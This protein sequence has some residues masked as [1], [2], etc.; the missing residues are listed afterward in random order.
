MVIAIFVIFMIA[1]YYLG[2]KG[3]QKV[4]TAEDLIVANWDL[5]LPLVTWSLIA[6]L[7]AAPFYFAAVGSGYTTG[8]WEAFAT[9]GGLAS[10]MILGSFIW[11]KPI[12]RLKAWTIG[13]YYGLR[14]ADRKLGA[15]A[16]GIMAAAFGFFN[17][18]ALTVGG[19][20]IIQNIFNVPFWAG[21][22]IFVILT[23]IYTL[24]GG[25]WSLA[26]AD[27]LNGIVSVV[28]IVAITLVILVTKQGE[29]FNS[30][31]W[32]INHLFNKGGADFWMLYLVLALG[33][34]PAADLGQRACG[35]RNPKIAAKSM[36]IAGIVI[37]ALA[38]TPGML[39]EAFKSIF[40]N[41]ENPEQL[42]LV[43]ATTKWHPVF[44]G[45]FLT[46]MAGMAMSTLAACFMSSAGI[47]IKN[48]HLDF[49][50]KKPAPARLLLISRISVGVFGVL[51]L[52]LSLAFQNV[53]NLA[54]LAWDIVFVTIFWPLVIPPF[55][56]GVSGKAVWVSI[57]G[58]IVVY[59]LTTIFG[60]P[61]PAEGGL[62][63]MLFKLPVFF[64]VIISGILFFVVSFISPPNK[65]TLEAHRIETS[66]EL[67]EEIIQGTHEIEA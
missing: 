6:A 62:L 12:R 65:A 28:G 3:Y 26:Y 15:Y 13:D 14:F 67:D 53:L 11:V 64:S 2:F 57:T 32:D 56:K 44:A 1:I 29:I 21:A 27:V 16:G 23:L 34:I 66:K 19:A 30:D 47:Y 8:G 55:W 18:G 33:D 50:N 37:L 63:W 4:N 36:L 59:I 48:I 49:I 60:V 17:A 7:L 39:G 54:Y 58:G 46:A 31:W 10:C 5:P 9:M 45:L 42:T 51:A 40:P 43:F 24:M 20:Y 61:G 25:L 22:L 38:W 35:A 41:V 52:I